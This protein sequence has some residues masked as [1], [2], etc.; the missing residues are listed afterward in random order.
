[1]VTLS[2]PLLPSKGDRTM[3]VRGAAIRQMAG[4]GLAVVSLL[5][6]STSSPHAAGPE[7]GSTASA[8]EPPPT[9]ADIEAALAALET[10]ANLDESVKSVLRR[11][12]EQSREA[13]QAAEAHAQQ[14]RDY[15]EAIQSG[16]RRVES[17]LDQVRALQASDSPDV[18]RARPTPTL[19]TELESRRMGLSDLSQKRDQ[20]ERQLQLLRARPV[21]ITGR[22]AELDQE[23]GELRAQLDAPGAS[24]RAPSPSVDARQTLLRSRQERA[25]RELEMLDAERRSQSIREELLRADMQLLEA[26]QKQSQAV[27]QELEALVAARLATTADR[28]RAAAS[29]ARASMTQTSSK[30]ASQWAEALALAEELDRVVADRRRV[31]AAQ[32]EIQV[33]LRSLL[34]DFENIRAQ[35]ELGLGGRTV[36]QLVFALDRRCVSEPRELEKLDVPALEAVR[37]TALRLRQRLQDEPSVPEPRPRPVEELLAARSAGLEELQR[38]YGGLI[39]DLA[40]FEQEKQR[41]R[42][43]ASEIES[44]VARQMFGFGLRS[45]PPLDLDPFRA[46][47]GALA[48]LIGNGEDIVQLAQFAATERLASSLVLIFA[49]GVLIVLR[50]SWLQTLER[51]SARARRASTDRYTETLLAL[52]ITLGLALPLPLFFGWSSWMIGQIQAPADWLW[53]F[54]AGLRR[55]T[56]VLFTVAFASASL[57]PMGLALGHFKWTPKPARRLRTTVIS[58]AWGYVPAMILTLS[59]SFGDASVHFDSLGRLSFILAHGWA[60]MALARWPSPTAGPNA[61]D[62]SEARSGRGPTVVWLLVVAMVLLVVLAGLG[63]L[64]TAIM[65]SLGLVASLGLIFSGAVLH[66]LTLRWFLVRRRQLAIRERL[67]R[68]STRKKAPEESAEEPGSTEGAKVVDDDEGELDLSTV[69]L[70]IR[71]LLGSLYTLATLLAVV[72]F[73]STAFP[74]AELARSTPMTPLGGLTLLQLAQIVLIV[75]LATIL[76]KNLPGLLELTL[77]RPARIIPGTRFAIATL[78]QYATIAVGVA[79]VLQVI[80]VDWAQ[81]GWIAAAL[82]VGLGFGLQ[83]IV[84]NF[85]SGLIILFERPIR[86][87]DIV[88]VEGTTGTVTRIQM[89]STTVVNWDGQEFVV[90][91]KTLV[92]NTLLNWTLSNPMNR[93]VIEVGVA[94]G[95]DT[96]RAL[97]ILLEV[98]QAHPNVLDEPAPLAT[99]DRFADSTL[100]LILRAHL[101]DLSARLGTISALHAEIHRRFAEAGI[102]IAFPQRDLHLRTGWERL[103]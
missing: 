9:M 64:I 27:V 76:V 99:F 29:A 95:S 80:Q 63:Y 20:I 4:V 59:C 72:A 101:P 23:L 26:Q 38:Q 66:A 30:A 33:R 93:V 11:E 52:L 74:L 73:W 78:V 51:T 43:Q 47:P 53:G 16:P 45:S 77:F 98:A 32:A 7:G 84:A 36:V 50:P 91:N 34:A 54:R 57:R 97:E 68:A 89:R 86:V 60:A 65:L 96:D 56:W 44:F 15:R 24:A 25:T 42:D 14:A 46:L 90:P 102:E 17:L 41:V 88:T 3:G 39:R 37:V 48:W 12:Y 18:D 6:L 83:E 35:L 81:F 22:V 75:L 82:S 71:S 103:R 70:Q 31:E 87:G 13:L 19:Q 61:N 10:D 28:I 69:T 94:Y 8:A 55:A 67:D 58:V 79:F 5:L 100:N 49:L 40:A 92:T 21:A 2:T 85:I 62:E 1:M